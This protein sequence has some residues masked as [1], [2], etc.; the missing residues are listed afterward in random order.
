MKCRLGMAKYCVSFLFGTSKK[1]SRYKPVV[2]KIVAICNFAL[3]RKHAITHEKTV[4]I[5]ITMIAE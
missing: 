3:F 1:R 5:H 2:K 4:V